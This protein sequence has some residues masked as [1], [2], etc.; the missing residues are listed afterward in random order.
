VAQESFGRWSN[1]GPRDDQLPAVR[2]PPILTLGL[3]G[4][5]LIRSSCPVPAASHECLQIVGEC[6]VSLVHQLS[7]ARGIS[8]FLPGDHGPDIGTHSQ[9]ALD[10]C[11]QRDLDFVLIQIADTT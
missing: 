1:K 8:A 5:G 6:R 10:R 4:A 11:S 2:W 3:N 7:E 9:V